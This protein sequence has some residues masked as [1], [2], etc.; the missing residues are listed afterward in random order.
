MKCDG[1]TLEVLNKL[2]VK[3]DYKPFI[4]VLTIVFEW[5]YLI[6]VT[7]FHWLLT[8]YILLSGININIGQWSWQDRLHGKEEKKNIL[9]IK[10][11]PL[12]LSYLLWLTLFVLHFYQ[13]SGYGSWTTLAIDHHQSICGWH[14][15]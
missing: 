6:N 2:Y 10:Y 13:I 14:N 12:P 7:F 8:T 3:V 15:N 11:V 5:K 9:R 1:F 4:F